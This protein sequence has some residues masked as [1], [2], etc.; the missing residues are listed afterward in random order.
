MV[1]KT[2]RCD[3]GLPETSEVE[4]TPSELADMAY[5]YDSDFS[6]RNLKEIMEFAESEKD[7]KSAEKMK[8]LLESR[9]EIRIGKLNLGQIKIDLAEGACTEAI[10][11]EDGT[12]VEFGK[13]TNKVI[14][15]IKGYDDE[16][17]WEAA[18]LYELEEF[19][20]TETG[21][22]EVLIGET[23]SYAKTYYAMEA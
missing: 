21:K 22:L 12:C 18:N 11:L 1:K 5:R 19:L 7:K 3:Y 10:T 2:I 13:E 6:D 20:A 4:G 16:G 17:P 8:W 14:M 15:V 23:I 9:E